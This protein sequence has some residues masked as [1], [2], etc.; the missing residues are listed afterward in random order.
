[1][2]DVLIAT[3]YY[4][5]IDPTTGKLIDL[6]DRLYRKPDGTFVLA[7]AGQLPSDPPKIEVYDLDGV[8][9]WFQDCPFQIRRAVI[10]SSI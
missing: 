1:M 6:Q 4:D 9:A 8:Y 10:S 2:E 7:I 3:R 5:D